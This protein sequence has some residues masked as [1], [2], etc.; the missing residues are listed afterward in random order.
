M[1][2][3]SVEFILVYLPIVVSCFF[4][5]GRFCGKSVAAAWLGLASLVFY[6]WDNPALLIPLIMISILVNF[7]VGRM[8][9]ATRSNALLFVGVAFNIGLLG[10]FKYTNFVVEVV[11]SV[12]FDTNVSMDIVLPLGISFY[13]FT[14][15]AFLVD[16]HRG[17]AREYSLVNYVLF[18]SFFPHLVAGPILHHRQMMPQFDR[19]E[20]YRFSA[21]SFASGLGWFAIGLFKKVVIADRIAAEFVRTSFDIVAAGKVPTF[22]D[23]WL[24]GLGYTFQLYFDF[25]GYSD[26][27]V[28]LGLMIG[29][30]L[31]LNFNS[32]Y[33]ADSLIEFWRRWH[34][35]L[36]TFLRDYL[37]IPLGGNRRGPIRRHFNLLAT[38]ILGGFWHGA[39]WNFLVW[40]AIHGVGLLVNHL[41]RESRLTAGLNLPRWLGVALTFLFVAAAWIPFRAPDLVSTVALWK[42]MAGMN[43]L[44][45]ANVLSADQVRSAVLW[46]LGLY[47]V[48]RYCPNTQEILGMVEH[49]RMRPGL[50]VFHWR[51]NMAWAVVI[52]TGLGFALAKTTV[53]RSTEFLYFRF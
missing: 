51:P 29:I 5:I 41:W 10:Y 44:S 25:S 30:T 2:F 39:A 33:R 22:I 21:Q 11:Q 32:P 43:G 16:C 50:A 13:T 53:A 27:A 23:A 40:G 18:V 9:V 1:L 49:A 8:L 35:T 15:I 31:P 48:V 47:V 6:G 24:L 45:G 26:M 46:V 52:G 28:G 14:Q 38:M 20:T 42:A 17:G 3:N 36:S 7:F 4:L 34:M 37:Y 12:F 19:A